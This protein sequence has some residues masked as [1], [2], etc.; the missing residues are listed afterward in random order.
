MA[1][2]RDPQE[3]RGVAGIDHNVCDVS[4]RAYTG[5]LL[6]EVTEYCGNIKNTCRPLIRDTKVLTHLYR[7]LPYGL[8]ELNRDGDTMRVW[9][10]KTRDL[11]S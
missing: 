4:T 9:L 8:P 11:Y 1:G 2:G 5:A 6:I 7:E 3:N 10:L